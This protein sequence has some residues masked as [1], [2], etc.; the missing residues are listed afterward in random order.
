LSALLDYHRGERTRLFDLLALSD[1]ELIAA[2]GG[3]RREALAASRR[4]FD[5]SSA[6]EDAVGRSEAGAR[7]SRTE[8]S[9]RHDLAYPPG[10]RDSGAPHLLHLAGAAARFPELAA[11]PVVAILGSHQ[12][13]EYGSEM[14]R[15]LARGLAVSGVAVAAPLRDGIAAAALVGALE[16]GGPLL[17][18]LDGGLQASVP[19]TL[20]ALRRHLAFKAVVL[21]ELPGAVSGRAWGAHAADR[22]LARL[23]TAAILV[24]GRPD[25]PEA[26]TLRLADR[27][28]AATG[29]I[30]GP[31]TSVHS[32]GP[33]A[34]L[35]AGTRLVRGPADVLEMLSL[36]PG[37]VAVPF[38]TRRN[39]ELE[40]RLLRVLEAV[41]SGRDTPEALARTVSY[42]DE[43]LAALAEL[44]VMGL[45][46]RTDAGRY[47]PRDPLPGSGGY[48]AGSR[49]G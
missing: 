27:H 11:G 14:A 12:S 10:L 8:R 33:H 7:G 28:G 41:G 39:V 49:P 44:E 26:C 40:P 38:A 24:E 3:R 25:G 6:C 36:Q 35:A 19:R 42:T 47:L 32:T 22:T 2:L 48:S 30:P 34:L 16:A 5:E 15:S 1:K 46:R 23:A 45:L 31:L 21:A 29:A 13:S 43:P 17:A 37:T 9:C 4:A 18:V 20:R